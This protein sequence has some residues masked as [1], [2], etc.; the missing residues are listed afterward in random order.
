M[1]RT[2]GRIG[3]SWGCPAVRNEIA[4]SLIDA[5]KD[6]SL[7]VIYYPSPDWLKHSAFL[8]ASLQK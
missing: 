3:R 4:P 6:G 1:I 7:L 5:I 2:Y 8:H